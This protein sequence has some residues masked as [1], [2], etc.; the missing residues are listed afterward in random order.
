[1]AVAAFPEWMQIEDTNIEEESKITSYSFYKDSPEGEVTLWYDDSAHVYYRFD[2]DGTRIDIPGVTSV[3]QII[4]KSKPLMFWAAR[5]AVDTVRA[6]MTDGTGRLKMLATEEFNALLEDARTKHT[7]RLEEAGDVGHIVHAYLEDMIKDAI[8]SNNGIMRPLRNVTITD[9]RVKNS[10]AAA[11]DWT[12]RHKVRFIC[13]ERKIYSR[14]WDVAGTG[15]AWAYVSSCDD[16]TCC[17]NAYVDHLTLLDWKT[18]NRMHGTYP[19]QTAIYLAAY[20][21]ETGE[22]VT[23]RWV[24][25]LDKETG[26]LDT[27]YCPPETFEDD[28]NCFLAALSLY[29]LVKK[30]ESARTQQRGEV[31]KIRSAI[32]K[33]AKAELKLKEKEAKAVARAEAKAT[34][35]AKM[36]AQKAEYKRLRAQGVPVAEAKA[37]A[38]PIEV[39]GP[40]EATVSQNAQDTPVEPTEF[41][42]VDKELAKVDKSLPTQVASNEWSL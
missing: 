29:R 2:A 40:V 24:L 21:E 39:V 42:K 19:T 25:R 31:R 17:P 38:Y 23:D 28:L 16:P 20:V 6:G 36:E 33:E 22:P 37:L 4:D 7:Q 9:E 8:A 10:L 32:K 13:T 41:T 15:D 1:M 34:K 14:E 30:T 12:M 27:L 35:V 18:S 5:L 26:K 11:L 3:L